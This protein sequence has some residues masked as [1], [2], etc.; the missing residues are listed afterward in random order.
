MNL[1]DK[2]IAVTGGGSGIGAAMCHRFATE[3]PR[4]LVVMDL[5]G[6][7]AERTAVQISESH[8]SLAVYSAALDVSNESELLKALDQIQARDGVIDLFVGNAGIGSGV[9]VEGTNDIWRSVIDVNLMAH[10]YAARAL[11]P[12]WLERGEGY[13][14][15]TASAAGLLTN[16]GD[17]PYTVTKHGA[18]ALAEWLSV[19]YGHRGI[20][21]SCL[22]PQGVRTPLLFPEGE[23]DGE[24]SEREALA[25]NVVR[26]QRILEPAEVAET[27]VESLRSEQ[28]LILPHPEVHDYEVA[29]ATDRER[30]LATMRR[31]QSHLD[32][33]SG[34]D[35]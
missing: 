9:G 22:C 12:T 15:I 30:W 19:T 32:P 21:V 27:V 25:L 6:S 11:V 17:A 28:F 13:M 10:V 24:L 33:A 20:G 26:A 7:A 29:R 8:P 31:I 34:A 2:V 16:L 35:Q 3:N 23:A 14:L 18:V 4:S 1:T 5:N